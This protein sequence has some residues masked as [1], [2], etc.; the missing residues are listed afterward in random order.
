MTIR[1]FIDEDL[2]GLAKTWGAARSDCCWPGY[3]SQVALGTPDTEWV[4]WVATHDLIVVT[5]DKKQN[6]HPAEIEAIIEHK[7]RVVRI[8]TGRK[9]RTMSELADRLD[10]F[11]AGVEHFAERRP[12]G[13]WLLA[14]GHDYI[15]ELGVGDHSAGWGRLT[16]EADQ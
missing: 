2:L 7:L 8:T 9:K 11:W 10:R 14:I 3:R 5:K 12:T 6:R 13:P 1:Y 4:P 16:P 15:E